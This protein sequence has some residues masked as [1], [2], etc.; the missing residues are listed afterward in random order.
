MSTLSI[1]MTDAQLQMNGITVTA[2]N[3]GIDKV[4]AIGAGSPVVFATFSSPDVVNILNFT[5]MSS[6]LTFSGT[7]PPGSYTQIRFVLDSATT[8][9]SYVDAQGTAHNNVALTVPSATTGGFGN[10]TSTDNGDG[11]GTAGIKVNV[12]FTATAN[13][14][15]GFVIDFNVAH[16]IVQ[17]GNGNFILKPVLVATAQNIAGAISGIVKNQAGT[18]AVVGAEVDAM[19]NGSVVNSAIT[20]SNGNFTINALAAGTYTL[21][22]KNSYTTM[23]GASV[24]ATGFDASVGAT[25]TLTNSVTVTAGQT[26]NVGVISD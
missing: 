22:V 16:S 20:D 6:P 10:N 5:S 9:I 4:E 15:T 1:V 18:T 7:I 2:V 11:Q 3:L 8:T 13:T 12:A 21:V 17:T 26:T 19:Q 25:L 23:A 24:T 14:V